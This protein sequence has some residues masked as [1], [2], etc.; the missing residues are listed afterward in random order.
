[1]K[2]QI[3][4]SGCDKCK[5]LA[6]NTKLAAEQHNIAC[7]IEKV[8]DINK[9]TE[10]GV[11]MT[12]ALVIDGKS[13][14]VGKVLS[15]DEIAKF[16][17]TPACDCGGACETPKPNV[18]NESCSCGTTPP[19]AISSSCC[20]TPATSCTCGEKETTSCCSSGGGGKKIM[21]IVLLIF[22]VASIAFM[23]LKQIKGSDAAASATQGTEHIASGT[24]QNANAMVVYYFHGNQ[25]CFT[26]NKIEELTK[27]AIAE[28]YAKELADGSVIF[29]SVNVEEPVNEHF[30]KD[31]QL[32]TRSVVMQ[33]HGK[34]EKFDAVWTLVREPLK[35]TEYI[36]NG[37]AKVMV[38]K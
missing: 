19:A 21:T 4:G 37:A 31:F 20:E 13:V 23:V 26:C 6:A 12:P 7:E 30:I 2:V 11:M 8:E 27:Q 35:F 34:F 14:S 18:A 22:V 15:A 1:M 38:M 10:Y 5:K 36:Q 24:L 28:K 16:M 32:S 29:K 17:T 9:I 3:L 25:R 33:K